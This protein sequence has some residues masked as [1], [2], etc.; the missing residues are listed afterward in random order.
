[1]VTKDWVGEG[2]NE[3]SFNECQVSV[4]DGER[5]LEIDSD[6]DYTTMWMYFL[7]SLNCTLKCNYLI[8]FINVYFTKIKKNFTNYLYFDCHLL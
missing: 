4:W 1:M 7:M 6:D 3:E 2:S 8:N 5:V